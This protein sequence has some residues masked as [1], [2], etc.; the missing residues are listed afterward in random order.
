MGGLGV[1]YD[2]PA[3]NQGSSAHTE[4]QSVCGRGLGCKAKAPVAVGGASKKLGQDSNAAASG[5]EQQQRITG[6]WPAARGKRGLEGDRPAA[7]SKRR[8]A[9]DAEMHDAG[10]EAPGAT[11]TAGQQ[12]G[13][14]MQMQQHLKGLPATAHGFTLHEASREPSAEELERTRAHVSSPFGRKVDIHRG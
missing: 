10:K 2:L 5:A 13:G 12:G 6:A 4:T 3:G 1:G 9:A 7:Q 11:I 8:P 14:G